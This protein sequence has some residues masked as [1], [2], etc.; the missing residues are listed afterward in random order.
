MPCILI[1]IIKLLST[2]LWH[3]GLPPAYMYRGM[4]VFPY[5]NRVCYQL[6]GFLPVRY[7]KIDTLIS[8]QMASY[9]ITP[10]M[11]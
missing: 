3:C 6:F 2:E 10:I 4:P 1:D 9:Y 7:V 5:T 8:F 11:S